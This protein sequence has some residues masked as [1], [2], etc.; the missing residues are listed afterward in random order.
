[1]SL[2][3]Q[4]IGCFSKSAHL[5]LVLSCPYSALVREKILAVRVKAVSSQLL[6]D[7]NSNAITSGKMD[8]EDGSDE[9]EDEE[10]ALIKATRVILQQ[11][12]SQ[13]HNGDEGSIGD[14]NDSSQRQDLTDLALWALQ[15]QARAS[16]VESYAKC[17]D[18]VASSENNI[19]T[20]SSSTTA[21]GAGVAS[22]R[23]VM[24]TGGLASG[25]MHVPSA[26]GQAGGIVA[27]LVPRKQYTRLRRQQKRDLKLF[28][29]DEKKRR[30]DLQKL[31]TVREQEYLK[32]L[33]QHGQEFFRFHKSKRSDAKKVAFAAKAWQDTADSRKE[34]MELRYEAARVKA[35][36]END[37]EAYAKLLQET[38]NDR[39]HY[40][41]NQTDTYLATI[42]KMVQEQRELG[43]VDDD[44]NTAPAARP[45]AASTAVVMVNSTSSFSGG[46]SDDLAAVTKGYYES[47]HNQQVNEKVQQPSMLKGGDLKEYQLSGLQWLVSLY[48][49]N[50]NGILADEMGLGKTIQVHTHTAV[51]HPPPTLA[52]AIPLFPTI[53]YPEPLPGFVLLL[54]MTILIIICI[55][56]SRC[57]PM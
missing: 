29:R 20:T 14:G 25:G 16:L 3:S 51:T 19:I 18:I 57:W 43:D 35:L 24:L 10:G 17:H 11:A 33:L 36:K 9:D 42:N 54:T 5:P 34:K 50:L 46:T 55:R 22:S 37:M 23:V 53:T 7:S 30:T 41:L 44:N 12:Q 56:L 32:E 52:Y 26:T 40:L 49:N 45:A 8:V 1:M 39:L 28:E 38:K 13:M 47:T 27:Q 15:R 2:Y 4:D 21:A 48:N 6:G 31:R